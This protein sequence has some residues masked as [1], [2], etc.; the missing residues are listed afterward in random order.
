MAT[1]KECK[2][3]FEIEEDQSLGDCVRRVVD[4]RQGYYQARPVEACLEAD[5]CA[6]Y[7]KS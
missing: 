7:I 6:D 3:F 4:P 1:C 5:S 2:H